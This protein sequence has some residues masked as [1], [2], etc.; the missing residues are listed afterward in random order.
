MPRRFK[1]HWNFPVTAMANVVTRYATFFL[2]D[3]YCNSYCHLKSTVK[4][5]LGSVEVGAS[6]FKSVPLV[7]VSRKDRRNCCI[8][9]TA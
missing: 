8:F 7:P 5:M 4:A 9:K 1:I 6:M 3:E 2:P